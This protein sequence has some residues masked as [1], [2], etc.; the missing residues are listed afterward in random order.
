MRTLVALLAV[1]GWAPTA[2]AQSD[3]DVKGAVATQFTRSKG[4]SLLGQSVHWHVSSKV[5]H[6]PKKARRGVA[7]YVSQ[8]I[9]ILA[10]VPSSAV[11]EIKRRGGQAC[12]RGHVVRVPEQEREPG[13]PAYAIVVAS[14]SHR[15]D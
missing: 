4:A 14:L 8:G 13:D 7:L 12:V 15:R 9:G 6:V 3:V 2:A 5:F 10:G 1:A 11:E